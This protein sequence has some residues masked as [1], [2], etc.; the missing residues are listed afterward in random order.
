MQVKSLILMIVI[1]ILLIGALGAVLMH[2]KK[3]LALM[4]QQK[5]LEEEKR[6]EELARKQEEKRKQFDLERRKKIPAELARKGEN[7]EDRESWQQAAQVYAESLKYDD[8]EAMKRRLKAVNLVIEAAKFEKAGKMDEALA[9]YEQSRADISNKKFV[10]E[11]IALIKGTKAY[12]AARLAGDECLKSGDRAGAIR[13]YE[14]ALE[15]AQTHRLKTD[16]AGKIKQLQQQAEKKVTGQAN[17]FKLIE[18]WGAVKEYFAL[19]AIYNSCLKDPS[20]ADLAEKLKEEKATLIK[21]LEASPLGGRTLQASKDVRQVRV[22]LKDGTGIVG[23]VEEDS[24]KGLRLK[25]LDD[26]GAATKRLIPKVVIGSVT[27]ITLE[28]RNSAMAAQ[29]YRSAVAA[30]SRKSYLEVLR[31]IGQMEYEFPDAPIFADKEEQKSVIAKQS[32]AL[33]AETGGTLDGMVAKAAQLS[34]TMCLTCGG[35]GWVKCS[36]CKGTAKRKLACNAC[37]GT[38][39]LMCDQCK[40][41]GKGPKAKCIK[42]KGK[43]QVPCNFCDGRGFSEILCDSCAHKDCPVCRGRKRKPVGPCGNCAGTGRI[44]TGGGMDCPKCGGTGLAV[45][46]EACPA[47]LGSGLS[48]LARCPACKGTGQVPEGK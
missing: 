44:A 39:N 5:A 23:E 25:I 35:S 34:A 14:T 8:A 37:V 21:T 32:F 26:V 38:G 45:S 9:A 19:L 27:D 22:T 36:V 31:V 28:D 40:G 43:G 46:E 18:H 30:Y 10:E 47:C 2:Q 6:Q 41:S 33:M 13:S 15:L 12:E 1:P 7:A 29:L 4:E 42:C 16:L 17:V 20:Y 3:Q 11:R 48:G 24:A